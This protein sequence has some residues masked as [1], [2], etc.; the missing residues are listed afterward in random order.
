MG[1]CYRNRKVRSGGLDKS[2]IIRRNYTSLKNGVGFGGLYS[3]FKESRKQDK[4][5]TLN[6]VRNFLHSNST[7]TLHYPIKQ[8]VRTGKTRCSWIDSDHQADLCVLTDIARYNRGYGY[9]LIVVDVLSRFI[10]CEPMMRK[11]GMQC[12]N[13][14]RKIIDRDRRIPFRLYT[15]AGKEFI[16]KPFQAL[17]SEND[18]EHRIPKNH[19]VKCALAENGV[20]RVKQKMY[21][22][23]TEKKTKTWL[24]ILKDITA[25]L[26]ATF[27]SSIRMTP[28]QVNKTNAGLVWKVLYQDEESL[29]PCHRYQIGSLVR[30]SLKNQL[31]RKGYKTTY[32]EEVFRIRKRLFRD[33]PAYII[34]DL[35]GEE[36]DSIVYEQELV[37]VTGDL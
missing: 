13:A 36:I 21:R 30:L 2:E 15:D 31:F 22:Y 23:F 19:D 14:Y 32:T 4:R 20:K 24:T 12:A 27:N 10:W 1:G 17:L 35:N 28:N 7:Y 18:I 8:R 37:L 34:E 6:D 33:P 16:A 26:N 29:V 11:T 25:G 5:I 9:I 3:L